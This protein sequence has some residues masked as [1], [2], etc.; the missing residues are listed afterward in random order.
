VEVGRKQARQVGGLQP[1][2][3]S[4]ADTRPEIN[5]AGAGVWERPLRSTPRLSVVTSR[6]LADVS[7]GLGLGPR[8]RFDPGDLSQDV[9]VFP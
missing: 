2:G 7:F 5:A 6:L 4:A 1:T 3:E 9:G 8:E